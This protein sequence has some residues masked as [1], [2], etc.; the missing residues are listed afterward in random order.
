MPQM[1]RMTA[2]ARL[3]A[4]LAVVVL[5]NALLLLAFSEL[6]G[7]FTL[8]GPGAALEAALAV[9]LING[10]ALYAV[11]RL[12]LPLGALLLG[13]CLLVVD[14]AAI[15]IAGFLVPNASIGLIAAIATSV[16]M[17]VATV[18][19]VWFFTAGQD[20]ASREHPSVAMPTT[21]GR[22]LG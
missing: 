22:W 9:G 3:A 18:L 4:G 1:P 11:S 14:V 15:V 10:A 16:G 17:A 7:S 2:A 6:L 12:G 5:L 13:G 19:A 20:A 8:D 21:G